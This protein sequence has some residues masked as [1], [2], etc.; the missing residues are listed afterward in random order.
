MFFSLINHRGTFIIAKH[1]GS[2]IQ[3]M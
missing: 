3:T 2:Y 1:D